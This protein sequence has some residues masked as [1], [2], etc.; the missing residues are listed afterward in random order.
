MGGR[1]SGR[2][3]AGSRAVAGPPEPARRPPGGVDAMGGD[4]APSEIVAG[5]RQAAAELGIAV[6]LVGDPARLGDTGDLAVWPATEVV[7]MSD[8]PVKGVRSKK[9]S[10]LVRCA[11]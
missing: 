5:A 7:T 9:D 1:M 6:L 3:V 11:E 8:D 10:S 2:P 4:K